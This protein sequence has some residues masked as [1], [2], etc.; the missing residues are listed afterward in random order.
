MIGNQ[1]KQTALLVI[2]EG[3]VEGVVAIRHG[4]SSGFE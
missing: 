2:I 1:V 3:H 4:T